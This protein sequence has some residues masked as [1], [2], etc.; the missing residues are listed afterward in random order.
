MR[1]KVSPNEPRVNVR[2][3]GN[4]GTDG[5]GVCVGGAVIDT[6]P[7]HSQK[8]Q[9]VYVFV[10]TVLVC[11]RQRS[12]IPIIFFQHLRPSNTI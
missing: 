7:S 1:F 2:D 11:F 3:C 10:T 9:V 5:K 12:E 8:F 6:D 4:S